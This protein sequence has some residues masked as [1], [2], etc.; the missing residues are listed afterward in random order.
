MGAGSRAP[1]VTALLAVVACMV[2]TVALAQAPSG[3]WYP[4]KKLVAGPAA[5]PTAAVNAAGYATVTWAATLRPDDPGAGVL[6]ARRAPLQRFGAPVRV[7]SGP[8]RWTQTALAAN[9]D[10]LVGWNDSGDGTYGSTTAASFAPVGGGFGAAEPLFASKL[11]IDGEGN[12]IAVSADVEYDS[13]GDRHSF[14][15]A[16]YRP[17]T[18]SGARPNASRRRGMSRAAWTSRLTRRVRP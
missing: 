10:S 12:A 9:G 2:P 16:A 6:V 11:A 14:V 7:S 8:A 15:T 1:V 4:A 18:V 3:R 17:A 13:D 5:Q